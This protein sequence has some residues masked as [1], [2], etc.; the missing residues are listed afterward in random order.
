MAKFVIKYIVI[1]IN[2][3]VFG[4]INAKRSIFSG[5]I[6]KL[7]PFQQKTLKVTTYSTFV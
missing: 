5:Q 7:N 4:S 1:Q 3:Q 2:G 6:D